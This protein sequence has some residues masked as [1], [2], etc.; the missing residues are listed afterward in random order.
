MNVSLNSSYFVHWL[1][2]FFWQSKQ[3]SLWAGWSQTMLVR[4]EMTIEVEKNEKVVIIVIL[5]PSST[6]KSKLSWLNGTVA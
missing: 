6:R 5:V 1:R 4:N 2:K 3:S